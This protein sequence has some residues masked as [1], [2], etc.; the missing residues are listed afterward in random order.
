LTLINCGAILEKKTWIG[1]NNHG[2]AT[3]LLPSTG[4]IL[5]PIAGV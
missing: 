4:K 1:D 3:V 5:L 2:N